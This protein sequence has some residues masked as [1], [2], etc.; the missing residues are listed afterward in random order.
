MALLRHAVHK[1]L[2]KSEERRDDETRRPTWLLQRPT[3]HS[4]GNASISLD[5]LL[6]K[7]PSARRIRWSDLFAFNLF[8]LCAPAPALLTT[9]TLAGVASKLNFVLRIRLTRASLR[10]IDLSMSF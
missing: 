9:L 8:F 3:V 7:N 10:N 6:I 5:A 1:A 2:Q 4:T